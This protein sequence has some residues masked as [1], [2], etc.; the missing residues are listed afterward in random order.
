MVYDKKI[1]TLSQARQRLKLK[2]RSKRFDN[3]IQSVKGFIKSEVSR[4]LN[5]YFSKNQDIK[6][7]YYRKAI[8]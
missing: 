5:L 6:E 8:L 7:S 1:T 3:L 4:I 2:T